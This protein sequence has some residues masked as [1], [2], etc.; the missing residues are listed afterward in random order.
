MLL[1]TMSKKTSLEQ[2]R[3]KLVKL[4]YQS[5]PEVAKPNNLPL[6]KRIASELRNLDKQKE[7]DENCPQ[8][9]T[10]LQF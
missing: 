5:N 7:K 4:N 2:L 6:L 1:F 10:S 9:S 3:E 8:S